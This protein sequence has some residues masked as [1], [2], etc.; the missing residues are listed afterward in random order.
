MKL[1]FTLVALALCACAAQ[2]PIPPTRPD[3]KLTP[4]AIAS[5]DTAK[6]C[7]VGYSSTVRKTSDA[8]KARVYASYGLINAP[9]ADFEIDHRVPL[10]LGGA[11]TQANLWPESYQTMPWN[12]HVKDKLEHYI[13]WR[14]CIDSSLSLRDGQ[15]LFLGDWIQAYRHTF[16]E[17]GATS[18]IKK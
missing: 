8:L 15:R 4:G 5:T 3:T 17:P 7:Q 2:P 10:S 12:A 9:G 18:S 16:G 1:I 6:V 14:V 13:L 11:D